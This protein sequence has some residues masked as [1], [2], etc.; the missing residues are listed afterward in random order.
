MI[1]YLPQYGNKR[2]ING[3]IVYDDIRDEIKARKFSLTNKK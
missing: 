2:I 3:R 1:E